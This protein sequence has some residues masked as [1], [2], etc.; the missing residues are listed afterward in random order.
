M[1]NGYFF[2]KKLDEISKKKLKLIRDLTYKK[3]MLLKQEEMIDNH[4]SRV[5][6]FMADVI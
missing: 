2:N 4:K 5:T 6:N 3:E 1:I